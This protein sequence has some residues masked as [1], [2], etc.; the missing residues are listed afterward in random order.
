MSEDIRRALT[1]LKEGNIIGFTL[2]DGYQLVEIRDGGLA[3][4][5]AVPFVSGHGL[6]A[7]IF[8]GV[9]QKERLLGGGEEMRVTLTCRQPQIGIPLDAVEKLRVYAVKADYQFPNSSSPL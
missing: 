9:Q 6:E 2:H 8:G 7:C 1:E 4:E 5:S 3:V